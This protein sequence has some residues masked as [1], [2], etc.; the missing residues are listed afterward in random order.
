MPPPIKLSSPATR[1]FWEIP[2]LFEDEHLLALNKPALFATSPD[3]FDPE[4]PSLMKLL[5]QGIERGAP[6][7]SERRLTYLMN[8]H[9]LDAETSGVLLLARSKQILATLADLFSSE[10]VN[11][12]CV[13]LVQGV[14]PKDT[15]VAEARLAPDAA[16]NGLM[17]VD[18]KGGKRSRTEF[19]IRERFAGYALLECRPLTHRPHQ[20]RVHLSHAGFPIA[21]DLTYRG[22]PLLLSQL[23]PEYRLKPKKTERPLLSHPALHVEK[24][25]L[26]HPVTAAEIIAVAPWQRDLTV[27]VKY[28]RRYAS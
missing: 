19:R 21:G 22:S 15:M 9:R 14:P 27:A 20:V 7:A 10:K 28:L 25:S 24:L 4:R 18:Q 17:R 1:E 3:R 5:H 23:K 2:V 13:A 26:V 8:A 11:L 6:W 16:G 12:T